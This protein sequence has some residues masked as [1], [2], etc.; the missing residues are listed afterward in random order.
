MTLGL[1]GQ[2]DVQLTHSARTRDEVYRKIGRT[3]SI[4]RAFVD[5]A[6]TF[7]IILAAL[8]LRRHRFDQPVAILISFAM[9]F[10]GPGRLRMG[11]LVSVYVGIY[12]GPVGWRCLVAVPPSLGRCAGWTRG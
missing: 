1:E 7:F 3:W 8:I 11:S 5:L 9:L 6:V 2:G 4:L 10:M 12:P